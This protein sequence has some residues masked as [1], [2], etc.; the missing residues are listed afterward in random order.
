MWCGSGYAQYIQLCLLEIYQLLFGCAIYVKQTKYLHVESVV[1]WSLVY[2]EE[3][4]SAYASMFTLQ[5]A[6]FFV[7]CTGKRKGVCVIIQEYYIM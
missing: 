1:F 2:C 4:G 5:V 6:V 7:L 3:E